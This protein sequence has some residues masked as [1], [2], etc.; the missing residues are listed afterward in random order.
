L[1]TFQRRHVKSLVRQAEDLVTAVGDIADPVTRLVAA[2][3]VREATDRQLVLLRHEAALI[4]VDQKLTH[5]LLAEA[6]EVDRST[7]SHLIR[8]ALGTER[9]PRAKK[10]AGRAQRV[11]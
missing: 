2:T 6:L 10:R 8:R 1:L 11:R 3:K 7:V 5:E 4:C 9:T